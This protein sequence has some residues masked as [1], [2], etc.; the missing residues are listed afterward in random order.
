MFSHRPVFQKG[1]T[2]GPGIRIFE[3][4]KALQRKG[5][6]VFIAE[7]KREKEELKENINFVTWNNNLL[8]NIEKKFDVAFIQVWC[9]DPTF[10]S[11]LNSI[12]TIVDIYAPYLVEHIYYHYKLNNVGLNDFRDNVMIPFYLPF[13]QGDFFVCANKEQF[14]YYLGILTLLGRINPSISNKRIIDIVPVGVSKKKPEF[15]KNVLKKIIKNKKIIIWPGGFFPWFDPLTAVK[16]I[17]IVKK[18]YKDIALVFVGSYN[19][20]APKALT[21]KYVKE[22]KEYVRKKRLL[23]KNIYFLP[24]QNHKDYQNIYFEAELAVISYKNNLE[25][26]LSSRTRTTDCFWGR[27]PV[28]CTEGDSISNLI[29]KE[30][31]GL[32]VQEKNSNELADKIIFYLKNKRE[33]E[34]TKKRI[35]KFTKTFFWDRIIEP[36]HKF[37]SKPEIDKYKDKFSPYNLIYEKERS[38]KIIERQLEKKDEQIKNKDEQ[39]KNKD[40]QIKNQVELLRKKDKEISELFKIVNS[41]KKTIEKQANIIRQFKASIVYPLYNLTSRVGRTKIGKLLTKIIK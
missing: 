40:E 25:A 18:K 15:K 29:K 11:K 32:T 17:E 4:A 41:Q 27:L 13:L 34:K 23:N 33:L 22:I 1:M 36:L 6:K 31:L 16:S 24:W 5:H 28:I 38:I 8:N 14:D 12:P 9:N 37:C 35:D 19:P 20:L 7:S 2:S 10:L 26:K 39:I 30:G 3:I 21:Y